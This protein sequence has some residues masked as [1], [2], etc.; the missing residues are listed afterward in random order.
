MASP[1][2]KKRGQSQSPITVAQSLYE[3]LAA[4]VRRDTREI[5]LTAASTL[6]TLDAGPR[7]ITELAVIQGVSQPSMTILVNRLEQSA[8][9]ERRRDPSDQRVVL[10][11]LTDAGRDY[12]LQRRRSWAEEF[13][14]LIEKLPEDELAAL[15]AAGTAIE[16]L[17]Q[18]DAQANVQGPPTQERQAP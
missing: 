2:G 15:L 8:L 14:Q 5:S 11:A 4:V 16:H 9:V 3:L 12:R 13:F 1:N 17:R 6:A 7:R 18:L 10:V